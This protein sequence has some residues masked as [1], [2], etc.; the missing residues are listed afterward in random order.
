[1]RFSLKLKTVAAS[2]VAAVALMGV[3]ASAASAAPAIW[4]SPGAAKVTGSSTVTRGTLSTVCTLSAGA[5][6]GAPNSGSPL[7]GRLGSDPFTLHSC[8]GGTLR[9]PFST[10][11]ATKSGS[12]FSLNVTVAPGNLVDPFEFPGSTNYYT[13]SPY[14]V[15]FTNGTLS[16]PSTVTYNNTQFGAQQGTPLRATGT[17]TITKSDGSLLKLQ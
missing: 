1:M 4:T 2:A 3:A 12:A 14:V 15:P 8:S 16:T 5:G 7:Q 6:Y 10:T 17:L 13:P 9:F 11:L